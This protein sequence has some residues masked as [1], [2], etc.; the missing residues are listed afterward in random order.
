MDYYI[1]SIKDWFKI[2]YKEFEEATR[3]ENDLFD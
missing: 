2:M 3:K 1:R